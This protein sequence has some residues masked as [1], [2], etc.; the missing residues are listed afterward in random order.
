LLQTV[1]T[2]IV[3]KFSR[4]CVFTLNTDSRNGNRHSCEQYSHPRQC[5]YSG[6]NHST[7]IH[8]NCS[9]QIF[10]SVWIGPYSQCANTH[11]LWRAMLFYQKKMFFCT[12]FRLYWLLLL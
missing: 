12:Y 11:L 10:T 4:K 7:N 5:E 1:R 9:V 8:T 2:N 6:Q 3:Q